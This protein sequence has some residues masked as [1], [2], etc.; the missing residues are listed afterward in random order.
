DECRSPPHCPRR[1]HV[2]DLVV[3]VVRRRP[4]T[5]VLFKRRTQLGR[6]ALASIDQ[7][8]DESGLDKIVAPLFRGVWRTDAIAEQGV[9]RGLETSVVSAIGSVVI[10]LIDEL[11]ICP[12]QAL[13]G[14]S[15]E[16]WFTA[17]HAIDD[18]IFLLSPRPYDLQGEGP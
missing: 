12:G 7:I 4:K 14:L 9:N 10:A 17:D 8:A 6:I 18:D 1:T 2:G 11:A 15:E 16:D 3:G 5:I 13:L